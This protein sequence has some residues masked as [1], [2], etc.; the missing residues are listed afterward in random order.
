METT[1]VETFIREAPVLAICVLALLWLVRHFTAYSEA[2]SKR[3]LDG[4]QAVADS[5]K[6]V[7]AENAVALRKVSQRLDLNTKTLL[8]HD[9]TVRGANPETLGETN[10]LIKR[11]LNDKEN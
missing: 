7:G 2:E 9:A 11:L 4:L 6:S 1:L 8:L 3:H 10:E 5:V